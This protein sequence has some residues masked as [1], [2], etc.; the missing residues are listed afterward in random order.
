MSSDNTDE[1]IDKF[2]SEKIDKTRS[3]IILLIERGAVSVNGHAIKKN[4]KIKNGDIIEINIPEPEYLN[5]LPEDIPI[6]IVYEDEYV[7][8]VN[9]P[10]GMVVHPAP[11]NYKGTLVNALLY[12]CKDSLSSINGVIRPGIVHRIDKD[13]SGL[14]IIAKTNDAHIKLAEQIKEHSFLRVYY[15]IVYGRLK[16]GEGTI[17]KPIGRHPKDRK[18][19]T[20]TYKNSKRAVTNYRVLLEYDKF[21]LVEFKLETGRT[22]QIRV[23]MAFLGHPIYG[24]PLYGPASAV[25]ENLGGQFLH[26]KKIGFIHPAT[27]EYMEF[28]SAVPDYFYRLIPKEDFEGGSFLS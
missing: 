4:Y 13:T 15:G 14:L 21:S 26:A 6:D 7:A 10:R 24:D 19:M 3:S 22:H 9:K 28:D 12:H 1:R 5:V 2:L 17:D 16:E 23:H 11:G 20:V 18:K 27:E 25:R 8:V